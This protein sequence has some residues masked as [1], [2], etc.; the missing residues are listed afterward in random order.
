MKRKKS[1]TVLKNA[2]ILML[3]TSEIIKADIAIVGKYIVGIGEYSGE[4]EIDCT[5]KFITPGFVDAHLH[6]ESTMANPNELVHYASKNGTTTFIADPHEA[7]N[8][9]GLR[10]IEY[11]LDQTENSTGDVFIMLPSCVP[12]KDSEDS[13]YIMGSEDM[14]KIIDNSRILGLGE[15]MDCKAV[16]DCKDSMMRK[17]ELFEEKPK[18]GHVLGLNDLELSAYAMSGILT[19]HECSSYEEAIKKIRNGMYI[20]IREGSAAKNLKNIIEGI[21]SNNMD[22][23]RF[24]FCTDDKH[25]E[26]I[27]R[28]GHI[29]HNIRKSISLGM[30][31]IDA[32]KI[33]SYNP[34]LCYELSDIG[35]IAPGKKANLVILNDLEKVDIEDVLF[36]GEI[37]PEKYTNCMLEQKIQ[38]LKRSEADFNSKKEDSSQDLYE[39]NNKKHNKKHLDRNSNDKFSDLM[40][41]IHIDGFDENMLDF[42][43]KKYAMELVDGEILTKKIE[44]KSGKGILNKVVDIE[45][46]H[47]TG[48]Y[49]V[50]KLFGFGI[51][52]GAIASSVSHDSHNV[53]VVGDNDR[54][55]MIAI[56]KLKEI[57]GGYVLVENARVYEY[58]PLPVMGLMT[59]LPSDEVNIRI[60]DMIKKAHQMGVNKKIE[61]F[62]TLS[63]IALPVIPELRITTN[64]LYDVI[65][66]KYLD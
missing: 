42:K 2:N 58:V 24:N 23:S 55:I 43:S 49:H 16:L 59:D 7:A 29:S 10:G 1:D 62:I 63:F 34:S 33:A 21:V 37:I 17:L 39:K 41:T 26:D 22:I 53:I 18:D 13:G 40:D 47:N 44:A 6:F 3:Q 35:M 12:A 56:E 32:Y 25:I 54:D 57:K 30:K 65:E 8:V 5:D 28:E 31:P 46:H 66:D 61:P 4:L 27:Q 60:S 45:R 51:Q 15:V 11:I 48:K 52:N 9:S 36:E 20:H 19:D 38:E 14:K 64:G 50:A